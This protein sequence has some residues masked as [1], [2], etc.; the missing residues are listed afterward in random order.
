MKYL[1]ATIVLIISLWFPWPSWA[2]EKDLQEQKKITQN[3]LQR[4]SFFYQG[5]IE[6][7]KSCANIEIQLKQKI[8]KGIESQINKIETKKTDDQLE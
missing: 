4:M 8:L 6:G 2:G 7:L 5:Y 1:M 3:D